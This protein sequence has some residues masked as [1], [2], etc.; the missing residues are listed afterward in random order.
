MRDDKKIR[1]P[2]NDRR[3]GL[4]LRNPAGIGDRKSSSQEFMSMRKVV[5]C[6][7]RKKLRRGRC[8][9]PTGNS[10]TMNALRVEWFVN[11]LPVG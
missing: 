1:N 10:R 4:S 8:P 9:H 2:K 3:A 11:A 7:A 6:L 5:E